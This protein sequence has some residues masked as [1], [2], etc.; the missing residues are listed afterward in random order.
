MAIQSIDGPSSAYQPSYTAQGEASGS[1]GTRSARIA[2]STPS[3]PVQPQSD[4]SQTTQKHLED[5]AAKVQ[6]QLN[7]A[8]IDLNFSVDKTSGRIVVKVVDQATE[9]VIRQIPSKEMLAIAQDLDKK[10]H[11]LLISQKV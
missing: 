2:A 8:G 10:P 5:A 6:K 11:G 4:S 1:A 3:D 7:D 9:K